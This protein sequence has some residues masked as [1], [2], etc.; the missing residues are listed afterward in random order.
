MDDSKVK[1]DWEKKGF[2]CGTWTDPPG[3]AWPNYVHDTDELVMLE[4]GEIELSFSGKT[5]RPNIGEAIL[6]PALEPHTV[7]NIG[8]TTNRW[9]YGYK[10]KSP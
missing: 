8:Q 2:S 1:S 7:R 5:F 10:K 3:Q 4:E 6:I 9:Y